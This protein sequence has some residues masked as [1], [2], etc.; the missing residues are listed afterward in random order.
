MNDRFTVPAHRAGDPVYI[1]LGY[2]S[3]VSTTIL[4]AIHQRGLDIPRYRTAFRPN[5][6]TPESILFTS[7]HAA[8]ARAD[9]MKGDPTD[10]HP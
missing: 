8:V 7:W 10:S 4:S 9:T 1:V 3:I 5:R 2:N 6:D